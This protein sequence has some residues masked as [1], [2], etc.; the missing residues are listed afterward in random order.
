[1]TWRRKYYVKRKRKLVRL[2]IGPEK[3]AGTLSTKF[4]PWILIAFLLLIYV[5]P[6]GTHGLFEPDEGRYAE[7]P[8]E[9]VESGDYITPTLN[10]VKYF[11][12]PVLTYWMSA[13]SFKILG[14]SEFA[15]RLPSALC[16]LLGIAV[17]W[18]L[19]TRIFGRGT[20]VLS[21]ITLGSSLLYFAIG[22]ITL[23]DMP[24]STF[25]TAA[26][27]AFYVGAVSGNKRWYS[28]FY[29]AMALA[30]L[31]KGLIGVVLPAGIIFWYVV[32]TKKWRLIP[33]VLYVP[34][35]LIFFVISVPW[36]YL[37][38]RENPD[39]FRFFFIQEHF[40]RY[41]TTMHGRYEPFWFF[42]PLIPAAV[43]PWTGFLPSLFAKGGVLRSP[44]SPEEKDAGI[45]LL[46]WFGVILLFFSMSGSKLIPYIV[47]CVPPIAILLA[48]SI[49]R[50]IERG[51]FF[52]GALVCCLAVQGLFV[53]ALF[54][55]AMSGKYIDR[56]AAL[57]IAALLSSGL[58]AGAF[59]AL[60]RWVKRRDL[61]GA[62]SALCF[63]ALVF[64]LC[65]QSLYIPLEKTRSA[66]RVA[67]S[68]ISNKMPD[69]RIAVYGE[70]L[71]G[72]PFYAKERVALVDA[73]GELEY[74]AS[75]VK[76]S[77]RSEW[78]LR[79][80]EFLRRWDSGSPFAVIIEKERLGDLFEGGVDVS[81]KIIDAEDY[82]IIFN[83]GER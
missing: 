1:M 48:A 80:R 23:T 46:V 75:Q 13:A 72:V 81:K 58:F 57:S 66:F 79:K 14:E 18:G 33:N 30:V 55:F 24:V 2:V 45:F 44:G 12:K 8:R 78:F 29:A 51:R 40:Q 36:F 4:Y 27:A 83:R 5:T 61:S 70:I 63:G 28:L 59:F 17:V 10:Y 22:T 73:L 41:T 60:I 50:M 56:P 38:C 53:A 49:R 62:V 15:A 54:I 9:M 19:A 39:F 31:T 35:I 11:E 68:L 16:A 67:Q 74:G 25:I 7:I 77:E 26:M 82:M 47:P 21:A 6:L 71:Q 64:T 43:M 37:V 42:L 69:E 76:E 65:L 20:G 3:T 52:G 34:G 32:F